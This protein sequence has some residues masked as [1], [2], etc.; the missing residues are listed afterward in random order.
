MT[1]SL[2][3]SVAYDETPAASGLTVR[4]AVGVP[5][6]LALVEDAVDLVA[7]HCLSGGLSPRRVRFHLRTAL[8][9]ALANAIVYGNR[10]D[11]SKR[12][13]VRVEFEPEVVRVHVQDEGDG[14]DHASLPD[15]TSPDR[16]IL[17]RGRGLFLI[18]HLVDELQFNDTGNALCMT[19]RRT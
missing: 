7:R 16:I 2:R 11:P 1:L 14:F 19:L 18:R 9:E 3:L 5:S 8:A 17:D 15:P 12:V 13:D 10:Q 6:D 4:L